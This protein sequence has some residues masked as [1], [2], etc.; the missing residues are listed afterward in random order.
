MIEF[1]TE[2]AISRLFKRSLSRASRVDIIPPTPAPSRSGLAIC[3]I[4]RNEERHIGDWLRFHAAAGVSDFY[5]YDNLSTDGTVQEAQNVPAVRTTILPWKLS[6]TANKPKIIIPQQ[7]MAYCHAICTFGSAYRWMAFIDIDE[8]LVPRHDQ[9]ILQ[10]LERLNAYSNISL[11][12]VMYGSSG[13]D[14]PPEE[15]APFAYVERSPRQWGP[16]L[17]FKCIVDPSKV[18]QVS[19]HKFQT[20]DMGANSSND[21]GTVADYKNRANEEFL[22][23][24]NIQLNHYYTRSRRELEA[25]MNNGAVSGVDLS[26]RQDAIRTKVSIIEENPIADKAA[27]DFLN[28][29]GIYSSGDLRRFLRKPSMRDLQ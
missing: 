11:P 16:L 8:L 17:N 6:T 7:I 22:S 9:D 5:L 13:H 26:K 2:K 21:T 3:A 14:T 20:S 28:R 18:S 10:A 27:V 24:R 29:K 12:W 23:T 19:V 1:I 15:A 4:M 25:K